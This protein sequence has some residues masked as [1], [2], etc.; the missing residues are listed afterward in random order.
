MAKKR[1]EPL[2]IDEVITT[3]ENFKKLINFMQQ[4]VKFWDEEISRADKSFTD[5][6]H[7]CE[8]RYPTER[9]EKTKV[10]KLIHDIATVRRQYKDLKQ[11]YD[12]LRRMEFIE[13]PNK[14]NK[15]NEVCNQV[16]SKGREIIENKRQYKTRELHELWIDTIKE[17]DDANG[18]EQ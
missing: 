15:F 7:F 1:K 11:L 6:Y 8:L 2:T 14:T 9:A 5:I 13:N 16:I 17:E 10:C 18:Y 12:V 4:N 3:V